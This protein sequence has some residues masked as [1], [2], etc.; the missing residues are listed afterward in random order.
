M[1]GQTKKNMMQ[2]DEMFEANPVA[3]KEELAAWRNELD[4]S[5]KA[6]SSR[7]K[8]VNVT[9]E[10]EDSDYHVRAGRIGGETTKQ[11]HRDSNFYKQIGALGGSTTMARHGQEYD[12]RRKKGGLT[13]RERYGEDY[14]HNIA[15]KAARTK[16][17]ATRLRNDAIKALLAEGFKIPTIIKLTLKD[18]EEEPRLQRLR[19]SGPLAQYLEE[20]AITEAESDYLFVSQSGKPLSLANTYTVMERHKP[21]E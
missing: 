12:E 9:E 18:L 15:A 4:E 16:Q 13:T 7:S 10:T 11:R 21:Q 3:S 6:K 8:A 20:R 19:E 14:Y 2:S 5:R 1:A 17:D